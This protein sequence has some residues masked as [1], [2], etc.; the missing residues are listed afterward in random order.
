MNALTQSLKL[1]KIVK[2]AQKEKKAEREKELSYSYNNG[3]NPKKHMGLST[4]RAITN[5][6]AYIVLIVISLIWLIPFFCIFCESFRCESTWQVGYVIP[7]KWGFDNYVN[8]FTNTNFPRWFMNTF[9][10]ALFVSVFQT[11]FVLMMSYGLSRLRFKGRKFLMNSMLI[12]GMFPGFLTLILL[13]KLLNS[14]GLTNENAMWGLIIVYI[15]SSGMG[16]YV[17]KGFFDTI[18]KSLDEAARIDGA[19]RLQIFYKVIMPLSKPII[20]YTILTAFMAPWGDFVFAKYLAHATSDGMNVAV[21]L[22]N[23]ISTPNG[24]NAN[25]TTFCAG[26]IVVAIPVTVLFMFLQKYYVEGVTGGAVK[27]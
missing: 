17:S 26:G 8:L 7:Q 3:N 14:W 16:Y 27:G 9:I 2:T 6:I 12:L 19:T 5:T 13:Y 20:I 18:S 4:K 11:L 23:L 22:Q 1:K 10:T 24:L 21:G 15:A 25:Y